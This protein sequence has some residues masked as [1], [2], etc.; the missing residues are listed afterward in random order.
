MY[1]VCI[2]IN[3]NYKQQKKI[4]VKLISHNKSETIGVAQP[5]NIKKHEMSINRPILHLHLTKIKQP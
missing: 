1:V 5:S 3:T 4:R 2:N